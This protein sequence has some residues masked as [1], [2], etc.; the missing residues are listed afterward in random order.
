MNIEKDGH[1]DKEKLVDIKKRFN[2]LNPKER[3]AKKQERQQGGECFTL[4]YCHGQK[5]ENGQGGQT[6]EEIADDRISKEKNGGAHKIGREGR[7]ARFEI[8]R[9]QFFDD[10][11]IALE[12]IDLTIGR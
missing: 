8:D 4:G 9:V 3:F 10:K 7:M 11:K 1:E 5:I 6:K 12:G 2:Q